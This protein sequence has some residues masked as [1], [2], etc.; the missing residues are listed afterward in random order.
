MSRV[1]IYTMA[2]PGN[3]RCDQLANEAIDAMRA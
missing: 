1:E 3:E 2:P